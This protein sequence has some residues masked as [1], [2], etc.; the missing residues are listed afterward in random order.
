MTQENFYWVLLG[1]PNKWDNDVLALVEYVSY[2]PLH[3]ETIV[4]ARPHKNTS[5]L[6]K[7][8]IYYTGGRLF[9]SVAALSSQ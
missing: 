2:G 6:N 4:I 1:K 3:Y 5:K 7:Y 8:T 9:T